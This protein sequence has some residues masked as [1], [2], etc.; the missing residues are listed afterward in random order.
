MIT[1]SY[2]TLEQ[3]AQKATNNYLQNALQTLSET[4]G[5]DFKDILKN[6]PEVVAAMISSAQ[7]EYSA[8]SQIKAAQEHSPLG[9]HL[10]R[11]VSAIE[12]FQQ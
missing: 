3:Q 1:A 8:S 9:Y 6:Y 5:E 10:E 7:S 12:G 4:T 2:D 11:L